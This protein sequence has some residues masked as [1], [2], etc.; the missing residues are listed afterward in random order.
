M[1]M[2]FVWFYACVQFD[3]QLLVLS[4]SLFYTV[5]TVS[6]CQSVGLHKQLGLTLIT[7]VYDI[8]LLY[9]SVQNE[10]FQRCRPTCDLLLQYIFK[11]AAGVKL[12]K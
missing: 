8:K 2:V 4:R 9:F 7:F 1:S 6:V 11:N 5:L 10:C 12:P 3:F